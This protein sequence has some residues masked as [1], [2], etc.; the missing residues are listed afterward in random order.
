V[1]SPISHH[2][3]FQKLLYVGARAFICVAKSSTMF[4]IY[5]TPTANATPIATVILKEYKTYED[6]FEKK[7][8]NILP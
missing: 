3:K 4:A 8:A 2:Q 6:V 7:N 1:N 5:A